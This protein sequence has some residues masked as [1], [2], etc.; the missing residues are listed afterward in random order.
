MRKCNGRILKK[1]PGIKESDPVFA[2]YSSLIT[3]HLSLITFI[4]R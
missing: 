2:F 1:D 3:Y 4:W